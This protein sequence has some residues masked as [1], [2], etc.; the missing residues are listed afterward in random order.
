MIY[1][2]RKKGKMVMLRETVLAWEGEGSRL[3]QTGQF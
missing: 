3:C 2:G 1:V